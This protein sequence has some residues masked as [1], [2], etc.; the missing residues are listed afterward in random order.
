MN[1]SKPCIAAARYLFLAAGIFGTL[2][3]LPLSK[4]PVFILISLLL[5]INS[6][7]RAVYLRRYPFIMSIFLEIIS[8]A[9]IFHL[10]G[11]YIYLVLFSSLIDITLLL[12]YEAYFIGFLAYV[13]L[14][15][16]AISSNNISAAFII[17]LF[18]AAEFL[19]LIQLKKELSIRTDT[20]VLYDQLRKNNYELETAKSRL[21]DYSKQ[22]EKIAQLEERNRIS[23]EIHDSIGHNLTGALMQ[24]DACIHIMEVNKDKGM[25]LLHR[26]YSNINQSIEMV[27][28]TV[29]ELRPVYYENY[30]TALNNLIEK[31]KNDTGVNV[32]LNT[33]GIPYK[34]FPSI[35]TALYRNIQE[36]MTNSVRHGM[37]KNI[38]MDLIYKPGTFELVIKDDGIGAGKYKKG[39]GISGM[40]ERLSLIG[41]KMTIEAENGFEITM[42]IPVGEE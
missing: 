13:I 38:Y 41:G 17:I 7:F 33:L 28:Q 29:K 24:V 27:R 34:L 30:S 6:Q 23:R 36:A 8:V 14:T 19:F 42:I 9:L 20:E 31:F 16:T 15:Y 26:V 1:K 10:Y 32:Y 40:E 37:S 12:D 2:L 11:G 3:T 18:Y 4:Y 35:E 25:E 21:I 39:F 22:V 5:L